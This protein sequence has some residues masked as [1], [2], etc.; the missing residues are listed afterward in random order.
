MF[1][2]SELILMCYDSYYVRLTELLT[3]LRK[4]SGVFFSIFA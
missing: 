4:H 1:Q 3:Y 2:N